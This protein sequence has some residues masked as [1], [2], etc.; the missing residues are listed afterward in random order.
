MKSRFIIFACLMLAF[1]ALVAFI[2]EDGPLKVILSQLEKFR[3][4]YPQEKVHLH[5]D[6][7]FYAVGDDIWFKAYVVDAESHQVSGLSKVLN[8]ELIDG[9]DSIRQTLRLPL[10]AGVAWGDIRLTDSLQEGNYRVRAYTNYMRNFGDEYFFDKTIMVGNTVSNN[11][12]T[13]ANY[14]YQSQG[15]VN[16]TINYTDNNGIPLNDKDVAYDVQLDF[17]NAA[18]GTAKTDAKGDIHISFADN[19][20]SALKPGIVHTV[21]K[22][23]KQSIS[24]SFP[25]KSTSTETDVQFFPEGGNQVDGIRSKVA[26]KAVGAD[27]LGKSVSGYVANSGG[28][29]VVEFQSQHAGMGAFV[30]QPV[31]GQ[32]YT[33]T[34]KFPDGSEKKIALPKAQAEGLVLGAFNTDSTSLVIKISASPA[35]MA[36]GGQVTLVAQ[37]NSA[38]KFVSQNKL[39]NPVLSARIPKS[40]FPTGILQ[41]TLFNQQNQPVA[42]RLVFINHNDFLNVALNGPKT[43]ATRKKV[44][45]ELDVKDTSGKPA[46]GSF[47]VAVTDATKIPADLVDVNNETTILTS[48]LLTSDLKGYV[49]QPNYYFTAVDEQKALGLDNLLLTQGWRRFTWKNILGG[50]FPQVTYKAEDGLTIT[51]RITQ[52]KKPIAGGKVTLMSS[53]G[54]L[55]AID[56]ITDADGRFVFKDLIFPDSTRFV[57][58]ARTDKDKKF[59]NI[60]L[61][62]LPPQLVSA[63]K[64][65]GE[66]EVNVNKKLTP[67]FKNNSIQFEDLRRISEINKNTMLSEVK[68]VERQSKAVKGSAS[69]APRADFV[70]KGDDLLTCTNVID[71]LQGRIPGLL[72]KHNPESLSGVP[73]LMRSMNI[74]TEGLTPMLL[75]LDGVTVS[76]ETIDD[77]PANDVE[78]IEVLTGASTSIYGQHGGG[79]VIIITTKGPGSNHAYN[80]YTPG[81]ISYIPRGYYKSREFYSPNYDKINTQKPDLRTTVFWHPNVIVKDGKASFE[82]F[83]SDGKGPYKVTVEGIDVHGNLARY[84]YNYTVN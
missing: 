47:S 35:V 16:A 26:F 75:V 37:S 31:A 77:V 6:K 22:I 83:N 18:K 34:V 20:S 68:I 76:P 30:F 58:Q 48:L 55:F 17:K 10:T 82:Y 64:N 11:I 19:A 4:E 33:A 56:T 51:G 50:T 53:Q 74:S 66:V 79:G 24:K 81:L 41:L 67:Y 9:Q 62:R 3:A 23:D 36:Q 5:L 21:L 32:T 44:K 1:G 59:V 65:A 61:D 73:Y 38:V 52:S 25:I 13:T 78:G 57:V 27:G 70:V 8:V 60:A 45:M 43:S 7:P 29:K 28:E 12:L 54:G 39:D 69:L 80:S 2:A 40:R 15:K 71:C 14:Q 63:N 46:T 72:V 84:V 42:E 49:E